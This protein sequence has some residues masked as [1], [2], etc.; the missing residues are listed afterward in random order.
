MVFVFLSVAA[1]APVR[2]KLPLGKEVVKAKPSSFSNVKTPEE[3]K[4]SEPPPADLEGLASWY[5]EEFNGRLTASGEIYDMYAMT[6]AHRTLPLGTVVEVENLENGKKVRV[7]IND[8]G[9]FV[10]GRVID[11]S[12]GAARKLEMRAQGVVRVRLKIIRKP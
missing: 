12:R 6:A 5:G 8:R 11:L 9:P 10:A 7:R 3:K 4:Q 1:C 2:Q